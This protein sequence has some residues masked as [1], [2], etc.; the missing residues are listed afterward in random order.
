MLTIE[1][2]APGGE[3]AGLIEASRVLI[4]DSLGNPVC[5]AVSWVDGDRPQT[6]VAHLLDD[7]FEM[8]LQTFGVDRVVVLNR[9]DARS[10]GQTE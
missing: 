5:L 6:I 9:L 10:I 1:S 2:F 3:G 8:L 4:R 7:D